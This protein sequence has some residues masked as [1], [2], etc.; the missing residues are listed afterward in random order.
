MHLR[1]CG[2]EEAGLAPLW[3]QR[4]VWG[5]L[6]RTGGREPRVPWTNLNYWYLTWE[7]GLSRAYK[8][9]PCR[10]GARRQRKGVLGQLLGPVWSLKGYTGHLLID[11]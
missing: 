7:Q 5:Y 11:L 10:S 8:I 6:A 3:G 2:C 1:G 9:G 4:Q